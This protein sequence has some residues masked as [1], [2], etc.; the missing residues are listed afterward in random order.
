MFWLCRHAQSGIT[1]AEYWQRQIGKDSIQK[2]HTSKWI[3]IP[4]C[5][6]ILWN[7]LG[8]YVQRGTRNYFNIILLWIPQA[9]ILYCVR[10]DAIS[11]CMAALLEWSYITS[12]N[13]HP[14]SCEKTLLQ[15]KHEILFNPGL[16]A[17]CELNDSHPIQFW[18][19][20]LTSGKKLPEGNCLTCTSLSWCNQFVISYL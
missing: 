8:K 3:T 13:P 5:K 11:S 15:C 14:A 7:L 12:W 17:F 16:Q 10:H 19:L 2:S 6:E 20:R 18:H 4:F 1:W 9:Q